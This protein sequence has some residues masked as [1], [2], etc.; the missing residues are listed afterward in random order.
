MLDEDGNRVT[1]N[2]GQDE[3]RQLTEAEKAERAALIS[4]IRYY[5]SAAQNGGDVQMSD[6][7]FANYQKDHDE[8]DT[9]M[10]SD[11]YYFHKN[12]SYTQEFSE[13]FKNI[14]DKAYEMELDSYTE[15]NVGF[16]VCFIYKSAP[17]SGAYA[18]TL[19]ADC[20]VDFYSDA[21][22]YFFEKN[23]VEIGEAVTFTE[24][25]NS[26]NIV[27]LPYNYNYFPVF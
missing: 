9:D 3:L 4:E 6:T 27:T 16:G 7:M 18:S 15:V 2:N 11:G 23:I 12:S 21:A 5:I 13:E 26:I 20:F 17:T 22:S 1:G 10:H 14:V 19:A 8:G 24:K 25:I